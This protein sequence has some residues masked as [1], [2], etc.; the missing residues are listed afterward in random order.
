MKKFTVL[1]PGLLIV[2]AISVTAMLL[3]GLVDPY[4]KL[5]ALTIAIILG[6][7]INSLFKIQRIKPGSDF[8]IETLLK[9]GI[10]LLG[11]KLDVKAV[12]ALGPRILLVV[13]GYVFIALTVSWLLGKVFKL[14][15]KLAA[16]IGVGSCICG[17]SAVVAMG[18]CI[19]A[20][21]K[22]TL[23]AVSIVSILGA[24][25]V[26]VYSA[27]AVSGFSINPLQYGV[28]SGL[29]LH[30]VAHALAAAYAKGE[31]A[32]EM[33][34]IVKM[35]R[36]CMLV[37]VSIILSLMFNNDKGNAQRTKF[38]TYVLFFIL[39][40]VINAFGI[41]PGAVLSVVKFT[42]NF[43]ILMAMTALGL[44]VTVHHFKNKFNALVFGTLLFVFLSAISLETILVLL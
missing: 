26:L 5:E 1:I 30:G 6:I 16:L 10:V 28:W 29:S 42:S 4:F 18:P 17:A 24:I 40:A 35:T 33:G 37:P 13:I 3:S 8:T 14:D 25:G 12:V 41:I 22:D 15:S 9:A 44:S 7:L 23:V 32:G 11:F 38:P 39:A 31:F 27:I 20:D 34:T 43:F 36:V 19:K 21:E 2:A